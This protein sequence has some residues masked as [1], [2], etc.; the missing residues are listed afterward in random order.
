MFQNIICFFFAKFLTL[1]YIFFPSQLLI[2]HRIRHRQSHNFSD[3]NSLRHLINLLNG[4]CS[5]QFVWNG[6]CLSFKKLL[7]LFIL[8]Q[9][10]PISSSACHTKNEI[11]EYLF[12][13]FLFVSSDK[14]MR[15][16]CGVFSWWHTTLSASFVTRSFAQSSTYEQRFDSDV[17]IETV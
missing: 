7:I 1:R 9:L 5:P 2:F 15:F 12:K 3:I 11:S 14:T 8:L 4:S 13:F 16:F 10:D 17:W 6:Q